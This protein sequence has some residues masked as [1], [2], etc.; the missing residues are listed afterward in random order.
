[1]SEPI[2]SS[3]RSVNLGWSLALVLR[4]WHEAVEDVV[5]DIPHGTRAYHILGVV[6]HEC[7]PTQGALAARLVIDRSVLTYLLDDLETAGLLRRVQ[8]PKDRRA[9]RIVA[10]TKGREVLEVA[11]RRVAAAEEVVLG[12]L[13]EE[14]RALFRA[15]ASQAADA[16]HTQDPTTDPCAA[17][18]IALRD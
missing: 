10:T 15:A 4:R 6:V 8:D 12:A 17:V 2:E 3:V 5:A 11:E 18:E 14:Q 1:M 9:R 7:P 16:L 13:P